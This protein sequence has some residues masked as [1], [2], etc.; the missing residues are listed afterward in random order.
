MASLP[1]AHFSCRTWVSPHRLALGLFTR[2]PFKETTLSIRIVKTHPVTGTVSVVDP[3]NAIE[4][5]I[6]MFENRINPFDH[7][8]TP[9]GGSSRNAYAHQYNTALSKFKSVLLL[10]KISRLK[11][12]I[13]HCPAWLFDLNALKP[14]LSLRGSFYAGIQVVS[15]RSIIGSEG[16]TTDFDMGFHPIKETSRE[17][18]VNMAMAYLSR[19]PL[20]PVQLFQVGHAY[21]V[22]D[23]HHRISVSR[24][25]GQTSIDAEVI[26]WQA[27]PPFP[28]QTEAVR[29]ESLISKRLD[30]SMG[31]VQNAER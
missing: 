10:G 18:W 20:P 24:A 31:T 7:F 12:R 15:I 8:E 27:V 4:K 19:L 30:T 14:D 28:W 21:F 9:N 6:A 2:Q 23:G 13:T 5:E 17:R 11:K 29:N 16:K 3:Y 25:F 1:V 26:N 22:R